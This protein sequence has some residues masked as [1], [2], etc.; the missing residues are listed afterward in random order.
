MREPT[1]VD[2]KIV[3]VADREE[4]SYGDLIFHD[5]NGTEHKIGNKRPHLYEKIVPDHAV[6]LYYAQYM[7]KKYICGAK[8]VEEQLPPSAETAEAL[9]KP[10]VKSPPKQV[11]PEAKDRDGLPLSVKIRTFTISYAKD[12]CANGIV[13]QDE[14]LSY[15]KAFEGYIWGYLTV[16]DDDVFRRAI[17]HAKLPTF[18]K[19]D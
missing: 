2:T 1:I 18:E 5:K 7:D 16:K 12:L 3:V 4:N 17:S 9:D 11:T 10:L 13:G 19:G 15:A 8:L 14:I 6:E